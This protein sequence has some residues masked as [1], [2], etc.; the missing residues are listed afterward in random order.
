MNSGNE[1]YFT[2]LASMQALLP[3]GKNPPYYSNC[4]SKTNELTKQLNFFMEMRFQALCYFQVP[5]HRA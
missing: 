5:R 2:R 1:L 4:R 3:P